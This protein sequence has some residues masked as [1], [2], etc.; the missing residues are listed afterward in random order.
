MRKWNDWQSHGVSFWGEVVEGYRPMSIYDGNFSTGLRLYTQTPRYY[1]N[2]AD[3]SDWDWADSNTAVRGGLGAG[4]NI[5][6]SPGL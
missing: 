4:S 6:A 1:T 2:N 5:C 3:P